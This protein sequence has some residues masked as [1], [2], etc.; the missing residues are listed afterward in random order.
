MKLTGSHSQISS[1][2]KMPTGIRGLDSILDGGLPVGRT[3]L[4]SG[5][6]GTGKTV[7]AV[8]L[9]YR[10]ALAGEP[11]ILLTFEEKADQIRTNAIAMGMNIADLENEGKLKI[12]HVDVPHGAIRTGDYDIKGLLAI[13]EGQRKA[14]G[15]KRIVIDAIDMLMRIFGDPVREREEMYILHDYLRELAITVILTVKMNHAQE[16]VYPFLD[17][18]A[19]CVLSLDQ[20]MQG[21]VR[22]RRM[23]VL[24][25][26]GS[27][28]LSNEHPFVLSAGGV[29]FMP[30]SSLSLDYRPSRKKV[31]SGNAG[32]DVVLG[33][34]YHSGTCVMVAG[35]SGS[36]KT[37]VACTFAQAA[38]ADGDKVLFVDFEV[39]LNIQT[40]LMLSV[41]IDLRTAM[42]RG[43]LRMLN[44]LPESQGVEEHLLQILDSMESFQPDHVIIDAVS[45]CRRMDSEE[46]SFDF[47]L[48]LLTYC[49]ERGMTCLLTNQ[50]AGTEKPFGITRSDISSLMDTLVVLQYADNDGQVSRRLMVIKSRGVNHS[51]QYHQFTISDK[52]FDLVI[53]TDQR[54]EQR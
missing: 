6:P 32:L 16:Q 29:V 27:R 23:K 5:G 9:L 10:F 37:M 39:P 33:G 8:E 15:A 40:D 11:G 18:M 4:L 12:L 42:E 28:F 21:Q 35:L 22:T 54:R 7:L 48:R 43:S 1:I 36:G 51:M 44:L 20:R 24:K 41:G 50:V 25:Y 53:G 26:R 49:R 38:C 14:L 31:T 45:A 13:I 19:D 47:L 52:G 34:G 2:P 46:A 3:I 17:F 30:V